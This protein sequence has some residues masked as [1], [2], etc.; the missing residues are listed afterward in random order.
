MG[1][2][3]SGNP[4]RHPVAG[5]MVLAVLVAGCVT[6]AV[7]YLVRPGEDSSQSEAPKMIAAAAPAG[8]TATSTSIPTFSPTPRRLLVPSLT[9]TPKPSATVTPTSPPSRT[10]TAAP[11]PTPTPLFLAERNDLAAWASPGWSYAD[12]LLTNDGTQLSGQP[13]LTVPFAPPGRRFAV[14]AEVRVLGLASGVCE[15]NFGLVAGNGGGIDWGAGVVFGCDGAIHARL[16]DVTDWSNGYNRDRVLDDATFDPQ[17][18]WHRYRLEVDGNRLRLLIDGRPLLE[19]TDDQAAEGA[20]DGTIGLW[21][22][23]VRLEVRLVTV[24]AL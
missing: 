6:G 7:A 20:D 23:G 21:S 13:W 12:R 1:A 5:A 22:Q 24:L 11:S 2:G 14:E 4:R 10:P 15:Q 3:V 8:A 9:A 16:T 17:N 18:R 19:A